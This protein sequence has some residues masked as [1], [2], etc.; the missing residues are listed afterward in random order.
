M[1]NER[2]VKERKAQ[3]ISDANLIIDAIKKLDWLKKYEDPLIIPEIIG[4]AIRTGILDAPHLI[5]SS[6][7]KG[8]MITMFFNGAC[9]AVDE[10]C[11]PLSEA[12]RLAQIL[13]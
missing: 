13:F 11:R 10:F 4:K 12:A 2:S 5:G 6:A 7:A 1:K 9:M 3:L 8:K